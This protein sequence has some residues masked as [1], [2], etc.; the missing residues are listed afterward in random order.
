MQISVRCTTETYKK[1]PAPGSLVI[2]KHFGY[3]SEGRIEKPAF[4]VEKI[5]IEKTTKRTN[6]EDSE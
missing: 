5:K 4:L 1:P 6:K 3:D 2:V